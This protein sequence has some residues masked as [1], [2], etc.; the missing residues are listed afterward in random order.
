MKTAGQ[1]LVTAHMFLW[2]VK[3]AKEGTFWHNLVTTDDLRITPYLQHGDNYTV[4]VAELVRLPL[5]P[6]GR[7]F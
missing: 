4:V 7:P 2:W 6:F 1:V 5:R 3:W